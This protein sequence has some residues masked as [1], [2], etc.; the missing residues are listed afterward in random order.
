MRRGA[1]FLDKA[2]ETPILVSMTEPTRATILRL[3]LANLLAYQRYDLSF[4]RM[5]SA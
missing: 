5:S 4:S 1:W 2:R 3:R